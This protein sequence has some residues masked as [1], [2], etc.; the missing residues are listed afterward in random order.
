MLDAFI[1]AMHAIADE[2]RRDPALLK[3][4]P[5]GTPVGRLDEVRA[6]REPVLADRTKPAAG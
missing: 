2:A 3:N 5:T 4:A 6:A 1:A